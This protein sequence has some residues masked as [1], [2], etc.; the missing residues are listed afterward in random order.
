MFTEPQGRFTIQI[1]SEWQYVNIALSH[2]ETS[3]FLFEYFTK[4]FLIAYLYTILQ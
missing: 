4:K 3:P 2:K 1:P